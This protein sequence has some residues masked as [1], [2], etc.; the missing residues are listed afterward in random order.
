LDKW[1][2]RKSGKTKKHLEEGG[3]PV[4]GFNED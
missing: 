3:S 1:F 4:S 2:P